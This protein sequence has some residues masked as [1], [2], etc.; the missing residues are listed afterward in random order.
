MSKAKIQKGARPRRWGMV[1]DLN[2][3]IGCQTCSVACKI[4]NNLPEGT[5][6]NRVL[7]VEGDEID[8]VGGTVEHPT[9]SFLPMACQHCEEPACLPVCPT[10][11]TYKREDGIVAIHTEDCIGCRSCIQACPYGVRVFNEKPAKRPTDHALGSSA[12]TSGV[13]GTVEKC[14]FCMDRIDAGGLPMCIE[15]CPARARFVGD[16]ND[17]DS[18]VSRLIR[19]QGAQQLQPE[20]GTNPSVYYIPVQRRSVH[21]TGLDSIA[22]EP[23]TMGVGLS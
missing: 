15:T 3:C 16:L 17:P 18:E 19:E 7:T 1:I 8:Q 10:G 2:R 14:D 23:S 9:L 6:W 20:M 22:T 5:W 21:R 4:K 13:R 12:V 11:A